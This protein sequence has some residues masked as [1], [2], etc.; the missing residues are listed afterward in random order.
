MLSLDGPYT[1]L[2]DIKTADTVRRIIRAA[3]ED[4][5]FLVRAHPYLAPGHVIVVSGGAS[6]PLSIPARITPGMSQTAV[7][8]H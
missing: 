6:K 3:G 4:D 7:L 8:A 5:R 2:A 1:V